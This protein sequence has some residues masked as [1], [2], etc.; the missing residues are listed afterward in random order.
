MKLIRVFSFGEVSNNSLYEELKRLD[1]TNPNFKGCGDEFLRNR[2]W[3]VILDKNKII[4]YC[5]CLYSQGICIF[6]RAWVDKKYRGKG[7][8]KRLINVRMRGAKRNFCYTV[9]TYTTPDNYA[10]ANNL[11]RRGFKM[12]NPEY[13][14]GGSTML[15][16][17]KDI[18][19]Q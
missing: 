6:V 4:A 8:Q 17:I 11:I 18:D 16:F 2:E 15:Y 12:Y 5:G 7:L 3:W 14:Y 1:K 9:I 19:Y 10:S 13:Q